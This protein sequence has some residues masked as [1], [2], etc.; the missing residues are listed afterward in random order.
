M[1]NAGE[2]VSDRRRGAATLAQEGSRLASGDGVPHDRQP[3]IVDDIKVG[4]DEGEAVERGD[5]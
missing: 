4:A 1:A 5:C 3:L 2:A